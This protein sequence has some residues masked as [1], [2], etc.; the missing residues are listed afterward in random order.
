VCSAATDINSNFSQG[1]PSDVL[2][3][4]IGSAEM[5]G[6]REKHEPLFAEELPKRLLIV[7]GV[8]GTNV[9]ESLYR[10]AQKMGIQARILDTRRAFDAPVW[11]RAI[12]WRLLGRRPAHLRAFGRELLDVCASFKPQVLITT[13]LAPVSR[14]VLDKIGEL[15]I[16]TL[17]F[18]TDDPWN[19]AHKAQWFMRA[20]PAYDIVYSPR[21]AMLA[22]LEQAGCKQMRF[23]PFGYDE[24]LF[25]TPDEAACRQASLPMS[26]VMFAGGADEDRVPYM[27]AFIEHGFNLSLYGDYWHRQAATRG[28]AKGQADVATLRL[29]I[30]SAKVALCLVRRANRDGSC[31]RTFEVPAVGACMLT[32]DTPEHR[33]IF[34]KEGEAVLYFDSVDTMLEKTRSLCDDEALRTGLAQ[35]AH[36]LI[37][38]GGH[39]YRHR[40]AAMLA[41]KGWDN[42]A[43]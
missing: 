3:G 12:N 2:P 26:D 35:R 40:L 42:A 11:L 19:P 32:E 6:I 17:N 43:R 20:L 36:Q 34:G 27:Q 8:G 22:D 5:S 10:A 4:E 7:G 23:L 9:G 21:R 13:G 1:T 14:R 29:A 30:A 39:T 37:T 28:V 38:T 31:M 16:R 33:E 24:D 18:L 25:F 41:G 15:N